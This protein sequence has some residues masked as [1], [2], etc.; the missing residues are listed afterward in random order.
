MKSFIFFKDSVIFSKNKIWDIKDIKHKC[1]L[2]TVDPVMLG[3]VDVIFGGKN[4]QKGIMV[5]AESEHEAIK[6]IHDWKIKTE[7]YSKTVKQEQL[8]VL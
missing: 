2:T 5:Q 3:F 7:E 8:K 1:P 6:K 4:L